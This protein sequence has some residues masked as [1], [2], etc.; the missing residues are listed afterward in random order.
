M[1]NSAKTRQSLEILNTCL[2][3]VI[4]KCTHFYI[5]WVLGHMKQLY[6]NMKHENKGWGS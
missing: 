6:K 5:W 2:L 4:K 1:L 3:K